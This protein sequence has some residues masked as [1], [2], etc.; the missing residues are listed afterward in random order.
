MFIYINIRRKNFTIFETVHIL[1]RQV[2]NV[3][4]RSDR[5]PT[6]RNIYWKRNRYIDD[7]IA[8]I[9]IA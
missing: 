7:I 4:L 6:I 1:L 5:K 9:E 8:M 2:L 3:E